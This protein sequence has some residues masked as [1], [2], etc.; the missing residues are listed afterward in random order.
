MTLHHDLEEIIGS[1]IAVTH[2]PSR[3]VWR[4]EVIGQTDLFSN[5]ITAIGSSK[6]SALKNLATAITKATR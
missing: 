3:A 1:R 6:E 2:L 5:N 4:A